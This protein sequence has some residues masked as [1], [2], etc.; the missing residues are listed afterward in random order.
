MKELAA[1]IGKP[2]VIDTDSRWLFLGVLDSVGETM[3]TL[4]DADAHDQKDATTTKEAYVMD[5]KKYGIRKNR[6]KVWVNRDT[7]VSIS[8]LDDVVEY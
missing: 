6:K 1:F 2:V 5:S 8:L 7:I 3:V 4:L